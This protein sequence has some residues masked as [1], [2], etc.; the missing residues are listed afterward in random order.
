[1]EEYSSKSFSSSEEVV[2][3]SRSP[4]ELRFETLWA[5]K[6]QSPTDW[7]HDLDIEKSNA[8]KIRRGLIVPPK[9]LRIKIAQYFGVDSTTIWDI[10]F[11]KWCELNDAV[12]SFW[13]KV[14]EVKKHG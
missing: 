13:D 6:G 7:Y 14:E 3:S 12:E 4:I 9:H 8:S 11:K 10:N 1:M 5:S 2:K